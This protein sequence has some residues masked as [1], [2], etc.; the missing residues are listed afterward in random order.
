MMQINR[1]A[2]ELFVAC[3][4]SDKIPWLFFIS[5][6]CIEQK[7]KQY[8]LLLIITIGKHVSNNVS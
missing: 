5:Q 6:I 2:N 8:M 3:F 7:V 4:F 1:V